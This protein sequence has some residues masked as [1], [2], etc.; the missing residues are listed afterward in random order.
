MSFYPGTCESSPAFV[1][2]LQRRADGRSPCVRLIEWGRVCML[3]IVSIA[4]CLLITSPA[5]GASQRPSGKSAS[6]SSKPTAVP[7]PN[8]TLRE[9]ADQIGFKIGA[10]IAPPLFDQPQ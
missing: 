8:T 7:N 2:R 3:K 1:P 5:L 4:L 6:Q 10:T 9:L